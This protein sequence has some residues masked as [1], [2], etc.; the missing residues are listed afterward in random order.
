MHKEYTDGK[1]WPKHK[2][3]QQQK[4]V[5]KQ[6]MWPNPFFFKQK[7]I[8]FVKQIVVNHKCCQRKNLLWLNT[9]CDYPR[10]V[11]KKI[12]EA[13]IVDFFAKS[14]FLDMKVRTNF[15]NVIL[16][17]CKWCKMCKYYLN[18]MVIL[19]STGQ[20]EEKECIWVK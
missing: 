20:K 3:W 16:I 4:T 15:Q 5:S 17:A 7:N 12:G 13:Q 1:N 10:I 19:C 9:R 2:L 14:I 18:S 11:K 8:I 6:I